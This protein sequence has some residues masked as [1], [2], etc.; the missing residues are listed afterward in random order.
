MCKLLKKK[1]A[2]LKHGEV[3]DKVTKH[4]V[5]K[6]DAAVS[7]LSGSA[8]GEL[9]AEAKLEESARA[10][11]EELP[12][13]EEK[14]GEGVKAKEKFEEDKA[15][16]E[17]TSAMK[18]GDKVRLT[19]ED[20]L[21]KL[22]YGMTGQVAEIVDESGQVSVVFEKSLAPVKVPRGLLTKLEG[23]FATAKVLSGLVRQS[24]KM[25]QLLL[26]EIG[27][28]PWKNEI[29]QRSG[30]ELVPDQALDVFQ[31]VVRSNLE[32][33]YDLKLKYVPPSL[34]RLIIEDQLKV[35]L[36][37]DSC[38]VS[39]QVKGRRVRT[40]KDMVS[41]ADV[42][43]MPVYGHEPPKHWTLLSLTRKGSELTYEYFDSLPVMHKT[44]LRHAK[45]LL[46]FCGVAVPEEL[47]RTNA[48]RQQEIECGYF[49]MHYMELKMRAYRGEAPASLQWPNLRMKDLKAFAKTWCS[50]L[51]TVRKKWA[52]EHNKA[53]SDEVQRLRKAL[54]EEQKSL[55]SKGLIEAW[56]TALANLAQSMIMQGEHESPVPLPLGFGEKPKEE[57]VAKTK[58]EAEKDTVEAKKVE[59]KVDK[60]TEADG[61]KKKAAE[62]AMAEAKKVEEKVEKETECDGDKKKAAEKA[63]VEAQK[64]EEK[65]EKETECDGDKKKAAEKAMVEAK[66]VEEKV[67]K[68][69]ETDG[70]KKKATVEEEVKILKVA[71]HK[72]SLK[73]LTP[74]EELLVS[75]CVDHWGVEDLDPDHRAKYEKVRDNGMS[76]CSSCRWTSGCFR[77]D[78]VKAWNYYVRQTLGMK[79]TKVKHGKKG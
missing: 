26:E 42:V 50:T 40:F 79:G 2:A 13:L 59:E 28:M 21:H 63:M 7:V 46:D 64:V 47:T 45:A 32:L 8:G 54:A 22:K 37:P 65:V 77:C 23:P 70:D 76:I 18:V 78:P 30:F 27:V 62:K 61:D 12:K 24:A 36:A 43:L 66:K 25:K 17:A 39:D 14:A 58:E 16:T 33:L 74:E 15:E 6:A 10:K 68:E 4:A 69:T 29:T 48:A 9:E 34:S 35:R 71:L 19:A 38:E 52:E 73:S 55:E 41:K 72:D 67:E 5:E 11:L 31:V 20:V 53:R 3:D 75:F 56:K 49:V 60:E 51:E 57:K 44:N 1:K